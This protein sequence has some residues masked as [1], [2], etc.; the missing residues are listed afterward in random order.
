MLSKRS[1]RWV[2]VWVGV[3]VCACVGVCVCVCVGMS[4]CGYEC[5]CDTLCVPNLKDNPSPEKVL[6]FPGRR[7]QAQCF[8]MKSNPIE[9]FLPFSTIIC[10][11]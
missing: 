5:V 9:P 1:K 10:H 7:E 3:C 2:G 4:G 6:S 11:F 8:R